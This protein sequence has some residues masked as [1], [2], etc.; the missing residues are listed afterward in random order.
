MTRCPKN[1]TDSWCSCAQCGPIEFPPESKL[2]PATVLTAEP[3]VVTQ[4]VDRWHT[5]VVKVEPEGHGL[6]GVGPV[7][8]HNLGVTAFGGYQWPKGWQV[9]GGVFWIPTRAVAEIDG[10]AVEG[11]H[12]IPYSIPGNDGGHPWGVGVSVVKLF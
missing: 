2:I 9:Q 5:E 1:V 4:Y 7:Y 12:K 8:Y 11:C 10:V 6:L 3:K